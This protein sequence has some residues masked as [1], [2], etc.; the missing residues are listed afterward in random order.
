M[1]TIFVVLKQRIFC[2]A[3]GGGGP[4]PLGG[5]KTLGRFTPFPVPFCTSDVTD[6]VDNEH[7]LSGRV[8]AIRSPRS[9]NV[10]RLSWLVL[11]VNRCAAFG[12]VGVHLLPIP[13]RAKRAKLHATDPPEQPLSSQKMRKAQTAPTCSLGLRYCH[14]K[15]RWPG[16]ATVGVSDAAAPRPVWA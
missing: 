14:P 16:G 3:T 11:S 7:R 4:C 5:S 8:R 15:A 6:T 12:K 1:Q 10:R 2:G 13:L 9:M